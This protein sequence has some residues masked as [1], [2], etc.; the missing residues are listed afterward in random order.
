MMVVRWTRDGRA[1]TEP[2]P[3]PT[4][5]WTAPSVPRPAIQPLNTSRFLGP[6]RGIAR[7]TGRSG[8]LGRL[9]ELLDTGGELEVTV[10]Q[11]TLGVAG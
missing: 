2:T 9:V 3:K 1:G 8:G 11:P 7:P 4:G 10:G 6:T 5:G